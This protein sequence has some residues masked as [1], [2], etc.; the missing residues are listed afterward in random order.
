MRRC[1]MTLSG[2][3]LDRALTTRGIR[4]SSNLSDGAITH[5]LV[6]RLTPPGPGDVVESELESA[7]QKPLG[8]AENFWWTYSPGGSR[9]EIP[10]INSNGEILLLGV[11]PP[12]TGST[13]WS[14]G[15]R[16]G[17][18][19]QMAAGSERR[20][21]PVPRWRSV[22]KLETTLSCCSCCVTA[23]TRTSSVGLR[24]IAL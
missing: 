12:H 4:G 11:L 21:K 3:Q 23:T 13:M 8:G 7:A 19:V 22:S 6:S 1:R 24:S 5:E 20:G 18:R 16:P 17:I 15:S 2:L 9:S 14:A 10:G